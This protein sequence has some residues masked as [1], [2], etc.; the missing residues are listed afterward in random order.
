MIKQSLNTKNATLHNISNIIHNYIK[1][2]LTVK[3]QKGL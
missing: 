3:M 2:V 1:K